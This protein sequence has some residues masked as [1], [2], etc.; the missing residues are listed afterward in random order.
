MNAMLNGKILIIFSPL[1]KNNKNALNTALRPPHN[2]NNITCALKAPAHLRFKLHILRLIVRH[3]E[4]LCK[5]HANRVKFIS[6]LL[7]FTI[8]ARICFHL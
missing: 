1:S 5:T 2:S 3:N 7:P 6:F 8:C 4:F